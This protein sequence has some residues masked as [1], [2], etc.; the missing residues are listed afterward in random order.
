[1]FGVTMYKRRDM[2][3]GEKLDILKK[4][5][6]LP[7]MSQRQAACKL[8]VSQSLLGRMLKSRQEIENASLADK[9]R[10]RKRAGKEGEVEEALKQWFTKVRDKDV[11]VTGPL[12]RQ[13][14]QNLAKEMGKNNFVATE[15]WYHRWKKRENISF[16]TKPH[17]KADRES[18]RS[19][20]NSEWP[21]LITQY[22]L[23]CV[24]KAYETGL[25]FRELPEHTYVFKNEKDRGTS[26]E[27]LTILCCAS[28]D[29]EKRK[30]LVIGKRKNPRCFKGVKNLPVDYT[31]NSNARMTKQIFTD[32]L[33]KWDNKL[34]QNILL[35]VD[36]CTA[37]S[38]TVKFKHIKLVSLPS[39]S[40]SI[41]QP[42]D[43][44][45]TRTFKAYYR[46]RMR[47]NVISAIDTGLDQ[48]SYT[49][50]A[51][52]IAKKISVLEGLHLANEA[53]NIVSEI[54]IRNCFRH[55][56]FILSP[57][58]AEAPIVIPTD[59]SAEVFH[60]WMD[61]DEKAQTTEVLTEEDIC[62][63]VQSKECKLST[64]ADSDEDEPYKKPPSTKQ[65]LEA[66]QTLRRGIQQR[67][68]SE[69]FKQHQAYEQMIEQMTEDRKTQS[70]LVDF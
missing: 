52:E 7:K 48:E 45:F 59:L 31:A 42:C 32:W 38:I 8:N 17:D 19:W 24:Y 21:S 15:G 47:K 46:T 57:K 35:L 26:K 34:H 33:T 20:I 40:T 27:R 3:A 49:L 58:E 4:Y 23:S 6:E 55:S 16:A 36:K 10:I 44:G 65:I 39:S 11:R 12:L 66:L 69:V 43:Q 25:Y 51:H 29:G 14:A 1:M 2:S 63:K 37:H 13:K 5:D 60:K 68:D 9:G 53:W 41:I 22:P 62:G 28:M 61:I 70:T 54:T 64:A 67:G 56:G 50:R 30:L 18:A